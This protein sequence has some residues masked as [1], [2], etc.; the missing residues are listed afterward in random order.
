MDD[1]EMEAMATPSGSSSLGE[2]VS[3][4]GGQSVPEEDEDDGL[5]YI[6][7]RRPSLD[8]GPGPMDTSHWHYVEQALPPAL[9]YT[10]LE[11]EESSV[12]MDDEDRSSTRVQLDRTDSYSSCYSFDSDDCEK[13]ILKVKTKDDIVSEPSE[14]PELIQN[15][16]EIR[17]PSLTVAFTFKAICNTLGKLSE[18]D[19]RRFKGMLW[20]RYP[21]SFNTSPQGM[22]MVDLVDR[23][24]E[25]FSLEVSMQITKTLLEEMGQKKMVDY[26]QTLCIRNEVR[27]DL[28]ETLRR[29]Y[30][31]VC[32]EERRPFDDA[33]TKLY[34]TSTCD[35]GPNIEHEV[36]KIEKLDSNRQPGKLLSTQD[37]LSAERLEHSNIKLILITGVAG[38]GK[39][40]AVRRLILDWIEERSHRHV[41]FLFPLPFREL[42]QFEGS[43]VS[44]LEV[45]HKLYPET[46]KLR[47][48]DYRCED[49]KMMFVF[50]GLDEYNGKLDFENTELLGDHTDPTTLNVIVVNLLR[51]RLLYRGLF[52]VF[53]RPQVKRCIPWDT[54]YDEIEVRGFCDPEKDEY[55]KRRFKDPDQA[56]Q[57]IAYINSFKTLRI[58]CH[59]P[60]FCSVVADECHRIFREQGTQTELPR[61]ITY[62]YTKL[63]LVLTGQ[64]RTFRAPDHSPEKERDFLMKLGKLAFTMLEKGQF[65]MTKS[66]WKETGISD[67]EAV[68]N[69]GLCTQYV[70]KPYV[71]F[72]E[73]VLSFIHPTMQE[74]LAALYAF[75]SF[76]NQGKNIFEQQL[77]DKVRGM[78]KGHKAMELYKSAVD[79]SLLYEDGKLDLFL[80]FLFG[81]TL[82][83]NLEL[84]QPFCTSSVKWPAVIE[85]ITALIRKRIR[86]NQYPARNDNL[87]CCLVELGVLASQAMSS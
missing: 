2:A 81:M 25:C 58:M 26:L 78:F 4:R 41:A 68:I 22:D 37:I 5:Y 20:K 85:D 16:N 31:E 52:L 9:S 35:N 50:D 12:E 39:S 74:Y 36:M 40:M 7:Q 75:L 71:L 63:L 43:K 38:S 73:K 30:C 79:R 17:H 28:S 56:A 60:L 62:M 67:E 70:T 76:R 77:K 18:M 80:R 33:F 72:H 10:S 83:S 61:S 6:P 11:T 45:I 42:K 27:H 82:K 3:G 15:P 51:G 65:K 49:C 44:L 46:K 48:E 13:R 14:T 29:K 59:L 23:L 19:V 47:E 69:S 34:I 54:H 32:E 21:Q 84:L 87:Q 24:L 55:F 8:L 57:V 64:L 66:D 1:T 53:S 86:E